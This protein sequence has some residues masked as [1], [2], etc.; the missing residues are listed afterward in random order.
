[1]KTLAL[2]P[3]L[4]E[5]KYISA[6]VAGAR[7]H[8]DTV[9]VSDGGSYDKTCHLAKDK[10]AKVYSSMSI[11]LGDNLIKGLNKVLKGKDRPH[12]IVLLDGDGQ[13]NPDEIPE[14]LRPILEGQADIVMG[15]RMKVQGMPPYRIFG[16]GILSAFVNYRAKCQLKDSMVGFLAIKSNAIPRL[17]EKGWGVYIELLIKARS[18]GHR[19]ASVFITPIYHPDYQDNSTLPPFKLGIRLL[20]YILKWRFKVEV[21]HER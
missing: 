19:L 12:V 8:V 16:N 5:E 17:T 15:N 9:V 13:H 6:V 10:G 7:K 18:N 2:I 11:G 1:M 21:L 20:W 3:T 14:L 4:N